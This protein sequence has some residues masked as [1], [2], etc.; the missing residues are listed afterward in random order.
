MAAVI[1]VIAALRPGIWKIAEPSPIVLVPAASQA[2]TVAVSEPYASAAHTRVVAEPLGLLHDLQLLVGGE[3]EAPVADVDAESHSASP[4][5]SKMIS[6]IRQAGDTFSSS[7]T[8]S[9]MS[10]GRDHLPR[11]A[12]PP[13]FAKSVIGVSTNAGQSAHD[14][15]PSGASSLF[16][17]S[18]QPTTPAFVAE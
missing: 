1:A 18:V 2:S 5:R 13:A 16:I 9:A 17:A 10:C 3:A 6:G 15:I 7:R 4:G 8:A 14:L 11:P 12:T